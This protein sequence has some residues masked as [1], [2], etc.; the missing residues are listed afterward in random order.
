MSRNPKPITLAG[1]KVFNVAAR[2]IE[3]AKI[4]REQYRCEKGFA[5]RQSPPIVSNAVDALYSVLGLPVPPHL[6]PMDDGF[7]DVRPSELG[8]KMGD[9]LVE[10]VEAITRGRRRAQSLLSHAAPIRPPEKPTQFG[11]P[12]RDRKAKSREGFDTD[13]LAIGHDKKGGVVRSRERAML[14]PLAL[15]QQRVAEEILKLQESGQPIPPYIRAAHT[16]SDK[17]IAGNPR[18]VHD[19]IETHLS[20]T[21]RRVKI[22]N[23]GNSA[24][25]GQSERIPL[26]DHE[27]PK[28]EFYGWVQDHAPSAIIMVLNQVCEQCSPEAIA[29]A[30]NRPIEEMNTKADIGRFWLREWKS[31]RDS[32]N[33]ADGAL[34]VVSHILAELHLIYD[35]ER[36]RKVRLDKIAHDHRK[37]LNYGDFSS[38]RS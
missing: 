28:W 13:Q 7:A 4:D 5:V 21:A 25:G 18:V 29:L 22:S 6:H 31:D 30:T 36:Q 15:L 19:Y 27:W 17:V 33:A 35:T 16:P 2:K 12:N 23:Y 20:V 3:Q 24:G 14:T 1:G 9:G 32:V 10:I 34:G 26:D 38:K 37:K 11:E 8:D